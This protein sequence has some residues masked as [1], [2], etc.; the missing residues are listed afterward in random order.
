M[1]KCCLVRQTGVHSMNIHSLFADW[2]DWFESDTVIIQFDWKQWS[3]LVTSIVIRIEQQNNG[4][5]NRNNSNDYNSGNNLV[6]FPMQNI[7][8]RGLTFNSKMLKLKISLILSH[9]SETLKKKA[10]NF[11]CNCMHNLLYILPCNWAVS[12]CGLIFVVVVAIFSLLFNH[13]E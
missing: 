11:L 10:L 5:S 7:P 1:T 9:A 6:P 3:R 12:L 2:I 4:S 13:L 8:K